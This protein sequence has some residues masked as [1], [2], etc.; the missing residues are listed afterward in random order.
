[1]N[2]KYGLYTPQQGWDILDRCARQLARLQVYH[3]A[4]SLRAG[5]HPAECIPTPPPGRT[6]VEFAAAAWTPFHSRYFR[7][8]SVPGHHREPAWLAFAAA[9]EKVL[10]HDP[11]RDLANLAEHVYRSLVEG[12][13]EKD[14]LTQRRSWVDPCP[15]GAFSYEPQEAQGY[16]ALHFYNV[17]MPQSPFAQP[18]RL[19]GSLRD[20]VADIDARGLAIARIGVDSW[21]NLLRPFQAL[22]PSQYVD[23]IT[24]TDPDNKGG[25]GWWGQ[26]IMRTGEFNE[27]RAE[28]L[29]QTRKFDFIRTHAECDFAAFRRHVAAPGDQAR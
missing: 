20:I 7:N 12:H 13:V 25:W 15:F 26:F 19:L 18:G 28:R 24:P 8:P 11:Q 4:N 6:L 14:L 3:L 1:M 21:V 23:S 27:E 2:Y 5:D 22:F 29:R 17:Y 9:L 10:Q 16:V